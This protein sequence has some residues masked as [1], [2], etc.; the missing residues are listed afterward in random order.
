MIEIL[1][2]RGY[3]EGYEKSADVFEKLL[4]YQAEAITRAKERVEQL[5]QDRTPLISR[6]SNPLTTVYALVELLNSKQ[7]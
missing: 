7:A 1:K 6:D 5:G 2:N 4:P 3:L